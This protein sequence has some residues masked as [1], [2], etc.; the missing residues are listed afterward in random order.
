MSYF[1]KIKGERLYLSPVNPAD[2]EQYTAWINDVGVSDNLGVSA[3]VYSLERERVTLDDMAKSGYNFAIVLRDGDRLLGNCGLFEINQVNRRANC[4]LF[5]GNPDDR[6][7]GFGSEAL[8]LLLGYAFDT[9]NLNNVMLSVFEFNAGAVRCYEK[10]GF[11][12]I[13]ERRGSYFAKGR[14]HNEIFMDII[15]EDFTTNA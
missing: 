12:R 14:Y 15:R 6:G 7:K 2:L 4:G 1:Q 5:I 3:M 9:L 11:K 10:V 13:G 8:R